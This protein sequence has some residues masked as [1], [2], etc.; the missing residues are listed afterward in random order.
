MYQC[1]NINFV[2][3]LNINFSKVETGYSVNEESI[4]DAIPQLVIKELIETLGM[5]KSL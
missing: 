1:I 5:N 4:Q 2:K 3:A